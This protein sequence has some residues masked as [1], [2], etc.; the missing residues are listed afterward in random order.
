MPRQARTSGGDLQAGGLRPTLRQAAELQ[1]AALRSPESR[2]GWLG[3]GLKRLVARLIK[4][5]IVRQGEFNWAAVETLERAEEGLASLAQRVEQLSGEVQGVREQLGAELQSVQGQVQQLRTPVDSLP[6]VLGEVRAELS[7]ST[8]EAVANV[9]ANVQSQ[10]RHL[11]DVAGHMASLAKSLHRA[12]LDLLDLGGQLPDLATDLRQRLHVLERTLHPQVELDHFDFAR[13]FRGEENEIQ[14]RMGAYAKL[15]GRVDR[16]LDIG[17]GR[18]EFLEACAELGI[19][20]TGIDSDHDMVRRCQMKGLEVVHGDLVTHL[21]SLEDRSLDGIF[22]A[23]VVEHLTTAELSDLVQI[24]A[25]K[26]R[27]GGLFIA[28]TINPDTFSALRWYYLDLTHRQP[29]PPAAMRFLLED[30]GFV[31]RDVLF[32]S[33]LPKDEML[34]PLPT[35]T[36]ADGNLQEFVTHYN[37]NAERLNEILFGPQDYA[38]IAER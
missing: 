26:L 16:V 5:Q 8:S 6:A 32:T 28:E 36:E 20:A 10:G 3:W 11:D 30:A 25:R 23:Q 38:I 1:R 2:F 4:F 21:D 31:V 15:Y 27:R 18:G 7:K 14:R 19:G 24:S 34:K 29:I 9:D 33:E 22:S 35:P 17:C 12:Q 13:R 37:E